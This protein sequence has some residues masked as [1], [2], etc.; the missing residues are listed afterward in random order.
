MTAFLGW[1]GFQK[2]V[3]QKV[4]EASMNSNWRIAWR[5]GTMVGLTV[6]LIMALVVPLTGCERSKS[7]SSG[8][9]TAGPTVASTTSAAIVSASPTTVSTAAETATPGLKVPSPTPESEVPL[10][11]P[12]GTSTRPSGTTIY[13]VQPNDTLYSIAKR[14][15]VTVDELKRLNNIADAESLVV[16]QELII[17]S[18]EEPSLTPTPSPGGGE[19]VHIVQKGENLFRIALKYGTTVQAIANRNN[20]VN[21][22]RIW[23]GQKLIIPLGPEGSAPSSGKIHVVQA[24]E[25]LYRIALRYNTTPWAIA[26]ANGLKNTHY[27][28]VG[29][30][31]RIP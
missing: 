18:G 15:N 8:L 17:Y 24:G 29:Q 5:Q 12:T 16:G 20:I 9:P 28:Y 14:Y 6:M 10:P 19:T 2:V 27:I 3:R 30:R 22:A 4:R 26:V 21:P 13:I 11:T 1:R 25:N 7:K 23:T 31:L